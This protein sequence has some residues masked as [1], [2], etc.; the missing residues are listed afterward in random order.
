MR[1]YLLMISALLCICFLGGC[2]SEE[3]TLTEGIYLLNHTD[4]SF[5]AILD[6][7]QE[8]EGYSFVLLY[9]PLSSYMSY[10]SAV[11]EGDEVVCTTSDGKYEYTF[12]IKDE[13]TVV[14][15]GEKSVSV[16]TVEGE[17][18]FEDGAE[19]VLSQE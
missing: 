7:K 2:A 16:S 4:E 5:T 14:F 13:S 18:A 17:S 19:F 10:G 6:L 1:K 11:L 8:E 9:D 3:K 12:E 15:V